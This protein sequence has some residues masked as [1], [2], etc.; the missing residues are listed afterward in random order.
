MPGCAGKGVIDLLVLYPSGQLEMAKKALHSLG[1]QPQGGRDPFPEDRPMRIGA[2]L[3]EDEIFR[4]HA[5]VVSHDSPEA[6]ELLRFRDRLRGDPALVAAYVADKRSIL[7]DGA[8][9]PLDYST[10]KGGFIRAA[11][12]NG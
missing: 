3:H 7:A 4:V 12:E 8:T 6:A 11:L 2:I 10:R 1:F 5:H 9:D